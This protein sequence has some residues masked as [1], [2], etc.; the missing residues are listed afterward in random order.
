MPSGRGARRD[1]V[2][3]VAGRRAGERLEP[4]LA[5]LAAATAT[6]RSLN[7]WVGFAMSSLSST[8]PTPSA[9]ASRGA[10]TSGV[11]PGPLS[12][13]GGGVAGSRSA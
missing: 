6:T 8:S 11:K 4:E 1:R 3:E 2:R 13:P 12:A 10:G 7:E 9:L 5:A